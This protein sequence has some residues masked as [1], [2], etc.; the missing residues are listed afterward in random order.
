MTYDQWLTSDRDMHSFYG[1]PANPYEELMA[2]I[3]SIESEI[4]QLEQEQ[5]EIHQRIQQLEKNLDD[6][7]RD[8][9]RLKGIM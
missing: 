7:W 1:L 6:A 8:Y 2:E 4:D 9:D 3:R 5:V